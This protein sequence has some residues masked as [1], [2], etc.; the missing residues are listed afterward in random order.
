MAAESSPPSDANRRNANRHKLIDELPKVEHGPTTYWMVAVCLAVAVGV[1]FLVDQFSTLEA[2]PQR[3]LFILV[4]AATLWVSEAIPAFAVGILVIALKIALLGTP[5]GVF[6]RSEKDWENFVAVLGHPL[7]WL[8]FGGFVLAAGMERC[9]LDRLLASGILSRFGSQPKRLLLGVML[10]SFGLSMCLSNTATTAMMVAILMPVVANR[11]VGERFGT[12]L[13]LG[14]ATGANLGGMAS[15]IGT[16]PNAIVVGALAEK[17][18]TIGFL[19][20]IL[21][22][23]PPAV[24]SVLVAWLFLARMT[25]KTQQPVEVRVEQLA[26]SKQAPT[27]SLTIVTLT[28]LA[29][30]GLWLSS[31]WHGIPTAAVA[32]LPIVVFTSTG[33]LGASEIRGLNYDVLFLMAGGLAL[34]QTIT[35]TGLSD[36]IVALLPLDL[37]GPMGMSYL[38]AYITLGLSNFM[39]NTAAT[40]VLAPIG[41]SVLPGFEAEV[42]VPIAFGASAAMC[43]PV[44]T[45]PNAIA[46]ATGRCKTMDFLKIGLLMA[47][48]VPL[49]GILWSRCLLAAG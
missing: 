14:C 21:L 45:P 42:A 23:L 4:L 11:T 15:L 43:L 40:N 19:D 27:G 41:V 16:P 17:E 26:S 12:I 46:F 35:E 25:P 20:W 5:G 7:V 30:L 31:Q 33:I 34:G 8:F 24:C 2:A 47:A 6:A 36:W 10:A 38:L 3:A 44:A 49:L 32:F 22:G 37:M 28:L 13:I 29:T 9:G 39:S 48:V 1:T 18:V